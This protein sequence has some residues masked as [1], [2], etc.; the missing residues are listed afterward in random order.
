M[1]KKSLSERD[2]CTKFITPALRKA[3]WDEMTQI[4]E[5]VSF[6]KGRITVRGKLASRG[7]GKRADY[8]LYY[9][10]N[11]PIALIEAKDNTHVIG[12][13]MQQG[14]DYAETLKIPFVFSSNGD[15][16]VFHDRAGM[17]AEKE[18]TIAFDAFPSP[19]DLW[20]RY[21][22]WKGLTPEAEA[23]D[24][25]VAMYGGVDH[26]LEHRARIDLRNVHAPRRLECRDSRIASGEVDRVA[27]LAV[28]GSG[29][30]RSVV[31]GC[32]AEHVAGVANCF[33]YGTVDVC[34]GALGAEQNSGDGC[35]EDAV[36]VF[37][38]QPE[39][40]ELCLVGLPGARADEPVDECRFQ[41][42][43]P[44]AGDDLLVRAEQ[45]GTTTLL[46]EATQRFRRQLARGAALPGKVPAGALVHE[47]ASLHV[48]DQR[49]RAV[50]QGQPLRREREGRMDAVG[51]NL[52]D[53]FL[54]GIHHLA[55]HGTHFSSVRYAEDQSA[56]QRVAECGQFVR[57][58]LAAR[59]ANAA[60]HKVD[61]HE[62]G[63]TVLAKRQA[64]QQ[65]V[66]I[67]EHD[68]IHS[69]LSAHRN[70]IVRDRDH[71]E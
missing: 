6:T 50:R 59:L 28:Q 33:D 56:A 15:G 9:K 58:S 11:V 34:V 46:K 39:L 51:A 17:S 66:C 13:G 48:D 60:V 29:D 65:L 67:P 2:I 41:G 4:R 14:L 36:V 64:R 62:P 23:V 25:V 18:T 61:F 3:G 45:A 21:R 7:K 54:Q 47:R 12:D 38:H 55:G 49:G 32:T 30:R 22:T 24:R 43:E 71:R 8:V 70:S 52:T 26:G 1:N 40:G 44:R 69:C 31:L 42:V 35:A 20:A 63:A 16:F 19:D 10:P 57:D 53:I 27:D 37:A 68:R 5:E